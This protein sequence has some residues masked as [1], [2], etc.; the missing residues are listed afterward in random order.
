VDEIAE[1]IATF[2]KALERLKANREKVP[3]ED[4]RT[5]YAKSYNQL[6]AEVESL[7]E[8]YC[9]EYFNTLK[10]PTHPGDKAGN[11]W[12]EK[13]L[14]AIKQDERKPGGL[15]DRMR[16]SLTER[17]DMDQFQDLLGKLYERL[18]NEAFDP[19][20]QRHNRWTGNPGNRW[21]YNDILKAFWLPRKE[22][23]EYGYWIDNKYNPIN[24]AFTPHIGDDPQKEEA[25]ESQTA[26]TV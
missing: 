12:L 17:Q 10:F 4:L 6:V 19:Y 2:E 11:E 22:N 7:G 18:Y 8:W 14:A 23:P 3:I 21:I 26:E 1:K 15:Y 13:K 16:S 9:T 24:Y 20:W 5:K 25:A